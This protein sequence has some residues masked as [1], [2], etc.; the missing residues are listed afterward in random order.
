MR[1]I[2]HIQ[3]G[4]NSDEQYRL[5]HAAIKSV[6]HWQEW[7]NKGK[8]WSDGAICVYEQDRLIVT[9][10]AHNSNGFTVRAYFKDCNGNQDHS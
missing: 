2:I 8:V 5:S 3:E 9:S 6:Q 4:T 7:E 1:L 10:T